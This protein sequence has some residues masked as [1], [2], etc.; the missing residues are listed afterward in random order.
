VSWPP[1]ATRHSSFR[2]PRGETS[3]AVQRDGFRS[4]SLTP[5]HL[6]EKGPGRS[7]IAPGAEPEVTGRSRP[8]DHTVKIDPFAT[9]LHICLVDPPCKTSRSCKPIPTLD[10]LRRE[11]FDPAHDCRM[12]NRQAALRHYF[13]QVSK[14]ELVTQ[15]PTHTQDDDFPVEVAAVDQPVAVFQLARCGL[16]L[17]KTRASSTGPG[18]VIP[19]HFRSHIQTSAVPGRPPVDWRT[20]FLQ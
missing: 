4:E 5:D 15:V 7:D 11:V 20:R 14:A 19:A 18:G 6:G 1:A 13:N 16:T 2:A 8:V 3:V 12:R 17:V 9:D 10:E